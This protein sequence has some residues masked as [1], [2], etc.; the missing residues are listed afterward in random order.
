MSSTS[1][2][3][4]RLCEVKRRRRKGKQAP[5]SKGI[6][7]VSGQKRIIGDAPPRLMSHP[8]TVICGNCFQQGDEKIYCRFSFENTARINNGIFPLFSWQIA[9][10]VDVLSLTLTSSLNLYI[11]VCSLI[12]EVEKFEM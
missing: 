3:R 5:A 6:P 4:D 12:Y 11:S 8:L 10:T 9:T 1:P 2:F 7:D